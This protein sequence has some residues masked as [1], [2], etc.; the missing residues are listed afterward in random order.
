MA[1]TPAVVLRRAAGVAL[2][3]ACAFFLLWPSAAPVAMARDEGAWSGWFA[4]I[5][6]CEGGRVR[7]LRDRC[8]WRI[9]TKIVG[10][11]ELYADRA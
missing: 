10:G 2:G 3:V 5:P 1:L 4:D 11:A 7:G 9:Q 8:T 6:R